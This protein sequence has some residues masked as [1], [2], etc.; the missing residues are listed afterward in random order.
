MNFMITMM[1]KWDV[2]L[3]SVAPKMM[4]MMMTTTMMLMMTVMMLMMMTMI[5]AAQLDLEKNSKNCYQE[6]ITEINN[7]N[8]AASVLR[9]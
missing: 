7:S 3:F 4:M 1:S 8:I 9:S 2:D 5:N 6:E